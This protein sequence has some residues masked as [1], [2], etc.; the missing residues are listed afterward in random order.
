LGS[1][2]SPISRSLFASDTQ[3]VYAEP[4]Y[5]LFGRGGSL[6]AQPFDLRSLAIQGERSGR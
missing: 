2:D 5:F 6:L 3:A 4:G 1:L